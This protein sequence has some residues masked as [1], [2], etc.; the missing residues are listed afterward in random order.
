MYVTIQQQHTFLDLKAR[1]EKRIES[2]Y[3]F[4]GII[5]VRGLAV[6]MSETLYVEMSA[7]RSA[8]RR[9]SLVVT[10]GSFYA[11]AKPGHPLL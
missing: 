4:T 10:L 2:K 1:D 3:S 9:E 11:D 6:P 8:N 7:E 5:P